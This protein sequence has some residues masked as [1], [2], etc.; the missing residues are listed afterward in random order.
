MKKIL[1]LGILFLLGCATDPWVGVNA[2]KLKTA[3]GEPLKIED[4][5]KGG[6]ILDYDLGTFYVDSSGTIYKTKSNYNQVHVPPENKWIGKKVEELVAEKGLPSI[7][8][9]DGNGGKVLQYRY[10]KTVPAGGGWS[11]PYGPSRSY[12]I[13]GKSVFIG[14]TKIYKPPTSK[15]TI[16]FASYYVNA[17]G[18]IYEVK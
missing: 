18:I 6:Q 3:W 2:D 8:L 16:T 14:G 15:K 11:E 17:S 12:S 4:D 1:L 13:N 9:D 7:T 10:E 5:G